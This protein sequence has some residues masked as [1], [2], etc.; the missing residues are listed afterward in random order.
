MILT[1][2]VKLKLHSSVVC[3]TQCKKIWSCLACRHRQTWC[4]L[5]MVWWWHGDHSHVDMDN[6]GS[7]QSNLSSLVMDDINWIL[8][9]SF[10]VFRHH[11]W[12]QI[13]LWCH[14]NALEQKVSGDS[15]KGYSKIII[16][17]IFLA[18]VSR[19]WSGHDSRLAPGH[20]RSRQ[21][22]PGGNGQ[23]GGTRRGQYWPHS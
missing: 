9:E 22:L 23:G 6:A 5:S 13:L 3:K 16:F 7:G 12:Q 10:G 19:A 14:F 2:S 11:C 18:W 17:Y 20:L 4:V 1:S 8:G 15:R 21:T